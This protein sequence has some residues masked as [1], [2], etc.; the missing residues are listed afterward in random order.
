MHFSILEAK[1]MFRFLENTN[2]FQN[3]WDFRP[4]IPQN[5][6]FI[7]IP[8][9]YFAK[10][11][12]SLR[13]L[14]DDLMSWNYNSDW[15]FVAQKDMC[16]HVSLIR[17]WIAGNFYYYFFPSII[18]PFEHWTLSMCVCVYWFGFAS[19]FCHTKCTV[20]SIFQWF[21]IHFQT[22]TNREFIHRLAF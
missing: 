21:S 2:L 15:T 9:S 8:I 20:S 16:L 11:F 22:N 14:L 10:L 7:V 6:N 17:C 3:P 5:D 12:P 1:R 18:Y 4:N 13:T 19:F